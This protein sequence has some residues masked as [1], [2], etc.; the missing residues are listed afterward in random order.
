MRG[1]R[2][3]R[4][5]ATGAVLTALGAVG[6]VA[7]P[8]D[9]VSAGTAAAANDNFADAGIISEPL[10]YGNKQ[11]TSG[12]TLETGERQV[13][14][15]IASTVWY[16]FTPGSNV[17]LVADTDGS[18]YDTALAA[19][20]GADLNALT[21]VDCDSDSGPGSSSLLTINAFVGE[22]YFFQVGGDFGESGNQVFNLNFIPPPLKGNDDFEDAIVI[23]GPLHCTNKDDTA[24]ATLEILEP[25]RRATATK[26]H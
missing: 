7:L 3:T 12:A 23:S 20:T 11:D 9:S 25:P 18:S 4:W 10:P 17:L 24:G 16:S 8:E 22:T 14:S 26:A 5:R 13:C 21:A 6:M 19:Y 2:A 15:G 1:E